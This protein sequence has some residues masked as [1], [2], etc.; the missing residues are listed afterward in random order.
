MQHHKPKPTAPQSRSRH[1]PHLTPSLAHSTTALTQS[2]IQHFFT[3]P[4][5]SVT[6]TPPFVINLNSAQSLSSRAT[7]P[8]QTQQTRRPRHRYQCTTQPLAT[9]TSP[10]N[11]RPQTNQPRPR[12]Q[13]SL[14]EYFTAATHKFAR[15]NFKPP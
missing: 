3:P 13:S 9:H 4:T 12:I 14:Q 6:M 8:T 2:S 15:S 1:S 10:P 5:V 7:S 11:P